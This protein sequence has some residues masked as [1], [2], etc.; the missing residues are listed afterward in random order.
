MNQI[1]PAMQ[2]TIGKL[3]NRTAEAKA[4]ADNRPYVVGHFVTNRCMCDCASCLWKNNDWRDVPLDELKR[5][6]AEARDAGF[7]AAALSGGEPFLRKDLG[8]LVSYMKRECDLS[9][10]VFTTGYFLEKRMDEVLPHIDALMVS[11]DSARPE[12]HDEIRVLPGLFDRL[13]AGVRAARRA[14]PELSVQL[15]C[16][17]QRGVADEIDDLIA[18]A[19]ELDVRISFD[20]ITEYRHGEGDDA[21]SETNMAMPPDEL[22]RVCTLLRDRKRAGAP[23][24]NSEMYFD[25][26]A[27]GR[28]GYQCHL[29]K[30]V[31]FVNGQGDL[32]DCLDLTHPIANIRDLSVAEIMQLPRFRQLRV[33][34]ERCSSCNS[35]TMV[36]LSRAWQNPALLA[37]PRG[38]ALA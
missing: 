30:I 21:Y 1:T 3:I 12:R 2:H 33:D 9:I 4:C 36:D 20:V 29:P 8:E 14:Y 23:I 17:V 32:E 26:F 6:Y 25:Y 27:E 7:V 18:L 15:N 16:C 31:M 19:R 13:V 38:I 24:V 37:Q 5:F 34:A 10:L 22:A 28:P 11:V 35:P